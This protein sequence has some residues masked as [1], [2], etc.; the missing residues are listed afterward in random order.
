MFID[1]VAAG[2]GAMID[3]A[4]NAESEQAKVQ[5]ASSVAIPTRRKHAYIYYITQFAPL[6]CNK[7]KSC[8][9]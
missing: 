5:S 4:F 6:P 1:S 3:Y 7:T 2:F 8:Q 9:E